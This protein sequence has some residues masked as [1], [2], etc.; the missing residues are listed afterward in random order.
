VQELR[1]SVA[2]LVVDDEELAAGLA[3][4]ESRKVD[5]ASISSGLQER[6]DEHQ[7]RHRA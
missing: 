6:A 3:S 4:S 5:I 2:L 7:R 1:V